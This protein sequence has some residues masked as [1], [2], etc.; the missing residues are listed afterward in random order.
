MSATK[1]VRMKVG[2]SCMARPSDVLALDAPVLGKQAGPRRFVAEMRMGAVF[3]PC[4]RY[5]YALWRE[6]GVLPGMP[7]KGY[8]LFV[9]LNPST[10][11]ETRDDATIRRC[12]AFA[13]AWG[14]SGLCMV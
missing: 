5:R 1:R 4:R 14:Y 6:W 13:Q 9:G 2:L 10:A 12:I 8:V 11:D 7:D 3:S